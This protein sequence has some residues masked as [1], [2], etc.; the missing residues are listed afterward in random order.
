VRVL[1]MYAS[2]TQTHTQIHTH[3]EKEEREQKREEEEEPYAS[4]A[5]NPLIVAH[6][7]TLCICMYVCMYVRE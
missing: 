1:S 7:M 3:K 4:K 6:P 2:H 5:L